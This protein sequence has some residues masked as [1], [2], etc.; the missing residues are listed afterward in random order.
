MN[1]P[2]G[3]HTVAC[4]A[5]EEHV[6]PSCHVASV[7]QYRRQCGPDTAPLSECLTCELACPDCLSEVRV[8]EGAR[9]YRARVIHTDSCPWYRRHQA[10]Q[11]TGPVPCGTV[12]AHRGPYKKD[13]EA[14]QP[15]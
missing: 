10:G 14:R 15:R 7:F 13:P 4:Y 5:M 8:T 2:H 6:C 1:E 3:A 9:G 12:V 11:V